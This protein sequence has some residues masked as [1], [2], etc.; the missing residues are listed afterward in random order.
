ME[1]KMR[2]NIQ[3]PKEEF[4]FIMYALQQQN[5]QLI[6]YM[7]S[8]QKVAEFCEPVL[9]DVERANKEFDKQYEQYLKEAQSL[10]PEAVVKAPKRRGRPPAK[11][12]GRP[13]KAKV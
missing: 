1:P 11:K 2:I 10:G 12:R 9:A 3:L 7:K 5:K 6:D 8:M 4:E 13:A